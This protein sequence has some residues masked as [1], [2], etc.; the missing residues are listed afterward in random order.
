MKGRFI[1]FII[2]C[3]SLCFNTISGPVPAINPPETEETDINER[4]AKTRGDLTEV[5]ITA[6]KLNDFEFLENFIPDEHEV[7]YLKRTCTQKEISKYEGLDHIMLDRNTKINF[8]KLIQNGIDKNLNWSQISIIES[9]ET[10]MDD[11]RN[12]K[13]F[14]I[15]QDMTGKTFN[16]SFD[17][18]KIKNKWFFFQGMREEGK[19]EPVETRG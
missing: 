9:S 11:V 14:L 5:L 4:G 7:D 3:L 16:M 12:Y 1:A 10:S 13:V 19:S 15:L 18:I 17:V 8:D 6:L 2:A